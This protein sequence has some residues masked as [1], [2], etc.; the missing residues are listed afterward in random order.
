MNAISPPK[1][2][3]PRARVEHGGSGRRLRDAEWPLPPLACELRVRC[4]YLGI[5]YGRLQLSSHAQPACVRTGRSSSSVL[6][7][8]EERCSNMRF[9]LHC[10]RM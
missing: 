10:N 3:K 5:L 4:Y 8:L 6:I 9:T 7:G 1:S 2:S